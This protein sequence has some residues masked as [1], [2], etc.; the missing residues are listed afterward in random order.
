MG[1]NRWSITPHP[2]LFF[3]LD[4]SYLTCNHRITR[5]L[6]ISPFRLSCPR[7]RAALPYPLRC[8]PHQDHTSYRHQGLPTSLIPGALVS[9][10]CS[11][12]PLNPKQY[13]TVP[14]VKVVRS[15]PQVFV[16]LLLSSRLENKTHKFN[17]KIFAFFKN[18]NY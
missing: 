13:L 16:S 7:R 10:T 5:L 6:S 17:E 18:H 12:H 11:W 1:N 14:S 2:A 9:V 8:P 3:S 15:R 4:S